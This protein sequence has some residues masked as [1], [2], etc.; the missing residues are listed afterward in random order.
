[1]HRGF[2]LIDVLQACV[3]FMKKWLFAQ[4]MVFLSAQVALGAGGRISKDTKACIECHSSVH[5]WIVA[6]WRKSRM[7][8]VTPAEALKKT[9]LWPPQDRRSQR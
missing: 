2:A 1:V 6:G 7:A 5:P 3:S 8:K 9:D 4:L